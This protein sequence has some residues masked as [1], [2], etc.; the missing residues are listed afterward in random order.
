MT[1][2]ESITV[3]CCPVCSATECAKLLTT[4]TVEAPAPV[5]ICAV[6]ASPISMAPIASRLSI[7]ESASAAL[8]VAT[9]SNLSPDEAWIPSISGAVTDGD[10]TTTIGA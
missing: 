10:P 8:A 7:R 1:G 2:A 3:T 4:E 9:M 6:T 5:A